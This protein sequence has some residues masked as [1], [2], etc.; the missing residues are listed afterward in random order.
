Q[1]FTRMINAALERL[2]EMNPVAYGIVPD[3][4]PSLRARSHLYKLL[5]GFSTSWSGL[6]LTIRPWADF[7]YIML[8]FARRGQV[9]LDY[10]LKA[11]MLQR[12]LE[13]FLA[14]HMNQQE[15]QAKDVVNF[16]K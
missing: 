13:T 12:I 11:G 7:F 10:M 4:N 3:D 5:Q 8:L 1:Q 14:T 16:P 15:K 6:Q 2:K 9:E